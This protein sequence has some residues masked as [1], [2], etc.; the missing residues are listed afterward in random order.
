V[1]DLST[2]TDQA[3]FQTTDSRNPTFW[4]SIGMQ[5]SEHAY[6]TMAMASASLEMPVKAKAE[7]VVVM[8]LSCDVRGLV[9]GCRQWSWGLSWTSQM[10]HV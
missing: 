1:V 7:R 6:E 9:G 2:P 3:H 5:C 4:C 10:V 8:Q